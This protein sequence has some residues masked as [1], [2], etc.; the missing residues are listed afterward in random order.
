M[1]VLSVPVTFLL[2]SLLGLGLQLM[3][4]AGNND[5]SKLKSRHQQ[6]TATIKGCV[7]NASCMTVG[8]KPLADYRDECGG[9]N[10]SFCIILGHISSRKITHIVLH[11]ARSDRR[12]DRKH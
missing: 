1:Y 7:G 9:Y 8:E 6:K 10:K 2:A 4:V 5:N 3:L 12:A 11:S